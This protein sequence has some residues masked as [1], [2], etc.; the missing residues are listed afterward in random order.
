LTWLTRPLLL[1]F[2]AVTSSGV[3]RVTSLGECP[4]LD[5]KKVSAYVNCKFVLTVRKFTIIK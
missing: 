2:S 4:P 5:L 1:S 3:A